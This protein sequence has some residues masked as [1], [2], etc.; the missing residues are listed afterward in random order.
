MSQEQTQTLCMVNSALN[1]VASDDRNGTFFQPIKKQ[2]GTPEAGNA[3]FNF[4]ELFSWFKIH[5]VIWGQITDLFKSKR[6]CM[7]NRFHSK[8]K[9]VPDWRTW[10]ATKT[11]NRFWLW[12]SLWL[13]EKKVLLFK[14]S[15]VWQRIFSQRGNGKYYKTKEKGNWKTVSLNGLN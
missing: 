7:N 5:D 13:W 14:L 3:H 4:K 12:S 2:Q 11:K 6:P 8:T 15:S 9:I 1:S 10:A